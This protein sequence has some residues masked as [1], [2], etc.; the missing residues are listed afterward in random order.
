MA[1]FEREAADMRPILTAE[2]HQQFDQN[3]VVMRNELQARIR[4]R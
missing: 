1:Q 2:Q 3:V 4:R